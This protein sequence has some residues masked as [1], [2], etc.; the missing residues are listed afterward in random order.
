M[1][2]KI[3][4][5]YD[6][7][8]VRSATKVNAEVLK[9]AGKMRIVGRAGVGVDNIDVAAATK[10]GIHLFSLYLVSISAYHIQFTIYTCYYVTNIDG[11]S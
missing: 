9:H 2:I 4:G 7:L 5:D 6:G 3:I 8:V 1:V 10:Q 11:Y